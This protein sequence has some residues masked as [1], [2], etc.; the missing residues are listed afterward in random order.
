MTREANRY[1]VR[2]KVLWA[3]L[4][5]VLLMGWWWLIT[6]YGE[7]IRL[8]V[9]D[10]LAWVEGLGMWGPVFFILVVT[11]SMLVLLPGMIFTL[12][13]GFLFGV[14]NGLL[15]ILAGTAL[16]SSIAFFTGRYLGRN[17]VD[18]ML[19]KRAR[20]RHFVDVIEAE[21]MRFIMLTRMVPFFPFKLSNYVFGTTNIAYRKFIIGTCIGIIPISLANVYTGSLAGSLAA[22]GSDAILESPI[23]WLLYGGGFVL[24][25]IFALYVSRLARR[26]FAP[27]LVGND[28]E[29]S[30]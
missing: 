20:T 30:H 26:A 22:L 25:V 16:G 28:D 3:L 19:G 10:L 8:T 29:K 2:R 13:G 15:Y 18:A 4:L 9:V 7:S 5:A 11:L 24:V 14:L 21:G 17:W 23:T 1:V 27:Y 6:L 12:S